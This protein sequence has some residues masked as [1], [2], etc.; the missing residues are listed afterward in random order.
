MPLKRVHFAVPTLVTYEKLS[1]EGASMGLPAASIAK[2]DDVRLAGMES[3]SIMRDAGLQMA[4]G[5]EP[6]GRHAC[7]SVGRI[8]YPRTRDSVT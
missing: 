8:R 1:S 2:V 3:L 5:S 4:Y 7:A 6:P